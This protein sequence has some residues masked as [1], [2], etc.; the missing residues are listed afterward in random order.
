MDAL[1][2]E[3]FVILGGPL[4]YHHSSKKHKALLVVS[5]PDEQVMCTRL[6]GD[7]W[8]RMGILSTVEIYSWEILLGQLP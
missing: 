3:R 5:A 1:E 4:G 6:S 2:A 8:M 7:P